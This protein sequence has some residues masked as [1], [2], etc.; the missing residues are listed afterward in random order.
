MLVMAGCAVACACSEAR[1][2]SMAVK[3]VSS[4][5]PASAPAARGAYKIGDPYQINGVWY[6]PAENYGYDET[7]IASWY[8]P[9]FHMKLTAN[10]ELFNQNDISAAH[11]TLPMPS[12]VRVTNL[13]NGRSLVVRVNDR[14]PYVH[15]RIIDMSRRA[16]QLLG[17]EGQG[18]A[19]VRVQILAGES[20]ALAM[21]LKG[22][23]AVAQAGEPPVSS[24]PRE[25]IQADTLP[26]PGSKEKPKPV[27]VAKAPP[28]PAPAP[29]P[30]PMP[31]Q[32]PD[33]KL[34]AGQQVQMVAVKATQLF[35]QA[36]AFAQYENAHRV[37][38]IL[39]TL[40]PVTVTQ[41]ETPSGILFRVRLGPI[42]NVGDADA[43]L[44]RVIVT[45][46]PAARIVVD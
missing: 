7:G 36:G 10:G 43:L 20:R 8:G 33:P 21:Q 34:L 17:F 19:K 28:P 5:T 14:G 35:I 2:A 37:S 24:A 3:E 30:T 32:T 45:G 16:A 1:L 31:A 23:V 42:G 11:R 44:E 22:G 26:A 27:I 41:V 38:A 18:T 25:S 39:S 29:A 46:Y 9:D 15:N 4:P 6:Y 40:G 13:E 12:I